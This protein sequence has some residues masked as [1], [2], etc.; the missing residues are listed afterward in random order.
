M[1]VICFAS[2][3]NWKTKCVF[4]I[5]IHIP[6]E[7][8]LDCAT[9]CSERH[10]PITPGL[11]LSQFVPTGHCTRALKYVSLSRQGTI[12]PPSR[13]CSLLQLT[14]F[15]FFFEDVE[16]EWY[17]TLFRII[18][19][20]WCSKRLIFVQWDT[21]LG[22]SKAPFQFFKCANAQSFLVSCKMSFSLVKIL[23]RALSLRILFNF[24]IFLSLEVLCHNSS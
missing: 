2:M 8:V 15:L 24:E 11:W 12:F 10:P 18:F 4:E 1:F 17:I 6:I 20:W 5:T 14:Y 16:T 22:P 19:F 21:R 7:N 13:I 9:L 23:I 3:W